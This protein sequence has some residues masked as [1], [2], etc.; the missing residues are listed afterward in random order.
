MRCQR[1]PAN[2]THLHDLE[3]AIGHECIYIVSPAMCLLSHG[4]EPA[5]N[6]VDMDDLYFHLEPNKLNFLPSRRLVTAAG[7]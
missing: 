3:A 5:H 2:Q 1:A 7:T 6:M 4:L